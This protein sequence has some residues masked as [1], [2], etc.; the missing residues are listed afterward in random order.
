MTVR[1][2]RYSQSRIIRHPLNYSRLFFFLPLPRLIPLSKLSSIQLASW[3][4][5]MGDSKE[6]GNFFQVTGTIYLRG[7]GG[8]KRIP[9]TRGRILT[10]IAVTV[11]PG[12]AIF[13]GCRMTSPKLRRHLGVSYKTGG[14]RLIKLLRS[15]SGGD[16][17]GGIAFFCN[18]H[19]T[20][21]SG[22]SRVPVCVS[23]VNTVRFLFFFRL[24]R[25]RY[26]RA[27]SMKKSRGYRS[28]R[29]AKSTIEMI[30]MIKYDCDRTRAR[31]PSSI[32]SVKLHE[33]KRDGGKEDLA[34]I[35]AAKMYAVYSRGWLLAPIPGRSSSRW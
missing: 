33:R 14:T 25:K 15:N 1:A 2:R 12:C 5:M 9:A 29:G 28:A 21:Y 8:R 19:V 17:P 23:G 7:R 22:Q 20:K 35:H 30:S 26:D 31:K 11:S 32:Y 24:T 4:S 10:K 18:V 16:G 13:C 34:R 3:R 6:R 27:D